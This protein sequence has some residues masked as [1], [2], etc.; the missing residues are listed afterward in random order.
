MINDESK[1]EKK[2]ARVESFILPTIS[3]K[4]CQQTSFHLSKFL[5][6]QGYHKGVPAAVEEMAA[7]VPEGQKAVCLVAPQKQKKWQKKGSCNIWSQQQL[8]WSCVLDTE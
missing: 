7:T 3:C 1:K 4:H 5:A 8:W 6:L 2:T